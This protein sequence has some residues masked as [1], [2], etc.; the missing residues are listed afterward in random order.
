MPVQSELLINNNE[1]V[2]YILHSSKTGVFYSPIQLA[3]YFLIQIQITVIWYQVLL[4]NTN[5]F[6]KDLIDS[7]MGPYQV[8]A[9]RIRFQQNV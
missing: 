3:K 8:L 9:L 2:V 4:S 1:G 5:N 6:Q 7:K